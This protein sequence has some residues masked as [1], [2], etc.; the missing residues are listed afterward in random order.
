MVRVHENGI[1]SV[2]IAENNKKTLDN[3]KS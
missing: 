3:I 2:V 1:V